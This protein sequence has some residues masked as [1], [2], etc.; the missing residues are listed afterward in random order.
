M[1]GT[2]QV[3]KKGEGC[4][5]CVTRIYSG[6]WPPPIMLCE[7]PEI[8]GNL[9]YCDLCNTLWKVGPWQAYHI[10]VEDL[11]QQHQDAY[12]YIEKHYPH[13]CEQLLF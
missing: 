4:K 2:P 1:G 11:R 6:T 7:M 9:H 10:T 8:W 12:K 3:L 5:E 13:I